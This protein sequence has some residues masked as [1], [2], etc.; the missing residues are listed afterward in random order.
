MSIPEHVPQRRPPEEN[1][2]DGMPEIQHPEATL[3]HLIRGIQGSALLPRIVALCN[4]K[5]PNK[6]EVEKIGMLFR[7]VVLPSFKLILAAKQQRARGK[8][9]DPDPNPEESADEIREQVE[10]LRKHHKK[11]QDAGR[12]RHAGGLKRERKA[13][14]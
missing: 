6:A 4:G 2:P 7:E 1:L 13:S 12:V 5:P 10:Q 14:Q 9:P 11:L 3:R 8:N